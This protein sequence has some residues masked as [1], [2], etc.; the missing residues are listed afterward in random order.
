M[1][2]LPEMHKQLCIPQ[3]NIMDGIP[4]DNASPAAPDFTFTLPGVF[5]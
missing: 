5:V 4:T 3:I 1:F 2:C